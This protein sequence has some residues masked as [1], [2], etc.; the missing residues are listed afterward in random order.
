MEWPH[1]LCGHGTQTPPISTDSSHTVSS[2]EG[3][4][5][6][7]GPF[8]THIQ[9]TGQVRSSVAWA[10][11]KDAKGLPVAILLIEGK[12]LFKMKLICAV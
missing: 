7:V 4:K 6:Q 3:Y 8:R 5:D 11:D 2:S 12:S 10:I 9:M 1:P